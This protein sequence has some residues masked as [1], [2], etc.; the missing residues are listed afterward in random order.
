KEPAAAQASRD[1]RTVLLL[2]QSADVGGAL[3]SK[4]DTAFAEA[5]D[6]DASTPVE[7]DEETVES[8]RFPGAD[9]A[10]L[11]TSYLTRK[12]EGRKIDVIVAQGF[13]SLRFAREHRSL[14]GNPP[15]VTTVSAP[16]QL[17]SNDNIIG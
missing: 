10:R 7:L 13:G 16:G 1:T 12:Y 3:R 8:D 15:I 14:F 11:F 6:A 2:Q 4:F 9:Q 5:L 17:N